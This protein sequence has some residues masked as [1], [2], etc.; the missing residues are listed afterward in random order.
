MKYGV[1]GDIHANIE[2]LDAVI[3]ALEAEGVAHYL[4]VGDIVGY[5]ADP[6]PCIR[7]VREI[8][9]TV[10]AGNHDWAAVGQ[11]DT[12]FFNAYAKAAIDWT[13]QALSAEDREWIASLSLQ[14]IVSNEVM[15]THAT[16]DK[17]E[18]FNYIQ[19]YYDAARSLNAMTTTVCFVGHS[20]VP[21]IFAMDETIHLSMSH[22]ADLSGFR[23]AL[24]NVGS[25]GQPR[26]ENPK[27][28]YGVY[29]SETGEYRLER[30]RYDL[31]RAGDKIRA[32][33]LPELLAERLRLGR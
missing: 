1:L 16:V 6:S 23:R 31:Q 13:A 10:V 27:A 7:R 14:E 26:D 25:I 18:E 22:R 20:H 9:A 24:V 29:D 11:L 15:V 3:E 28:A 4:S 8:G 21:L 5:G 33:G 19:S 30:V 2:A 17:P 12:S 32:A